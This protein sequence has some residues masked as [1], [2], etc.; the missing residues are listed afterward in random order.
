[1]GTPTSKDINFYGS[2]GYNNAIDIMNKICESLY[3]R[4]ADN[5]IARS[6]CL[7][8]IEGCLTE[9]GNEVKYSWINPHSGAKYKETRTY[10]ND[11]SYYPNLYQYENGAGVDVEETLEDG[12]KNLNIS[13]LG[14]SD[15]NKNHIDFL[16]NNGNA[17]SQASKKVLT[18]TETSYK[19]PVSD[20]N[21]GEAAEMLLSP[22]YYWLASRTI[23][24]YDV[25]ANYGLRSIETWLNGIDLYLSDNTIVEWGKKYFQN[26]SLRPIVTLKDS[27]Q[28][29]LNEGSIDNK[30][31]IIK[32]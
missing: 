6:I 18:L 11:Y 14:V 7:E 25:R 17:Y 4:K 19:V 28:I 29:K 23:Y 22:K 27:T 21:F 31:E 5:I 8:D 9:K 3:S 10:K 32:Y 13:G 26:H 30:H 16:L 1:M 15:S 20:E 12:L 24:C 2:I